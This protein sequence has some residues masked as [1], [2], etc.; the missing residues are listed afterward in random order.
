M[1]EPTGVSGVLVCDSYEWNHNAV[2][3]KTQ[4]LTDIASGN[5]ANV[6]WVIP[7]GQAS[8]HAAADNGSGPSRVAQVANAIGNGPY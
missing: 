2:I 3:S 5:L 4:V 6:S 1:C 8:D 7:T